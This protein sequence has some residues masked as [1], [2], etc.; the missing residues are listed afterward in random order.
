VRID[1]F[2]GSGLWK[3]HDRI[4]R[5]LRDVRAGKKLLNYSHNPNELAH[6]HD[7]SNRILFFGAVVFHQRVDERSI[8]PCPEPI[9]S[10]APP[11]IRALEIQHD[12]GESFE[13]IR[14]L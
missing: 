3:A 4:A 10:P 14:E 11:T 2:A 8:A 6:Q 7:Y 5:Y 13:R 12:S 1:D 9:F